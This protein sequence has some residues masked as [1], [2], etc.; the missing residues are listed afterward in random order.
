MPFGLVSSETV[1]NFWA[2]NTRRRVLYDYPNGTAPLMALTSLMETESTPYPEFKWEEKRW[3]SIKTITATGPTSNTWLYL[4]GAT[5]TAGAPA[6][7]TAGQALRVYVADAS[8]FQADDSI[9]IYN[10]AQTVGTTEL[11]GIVTGIDSAASPTFIEFNLVAAPTSTVTNVAGNLG[12]YVVLS[13][14]AY[15]EGARSRT[16]RY[17]FPY[18]VSNFT[19]IHKTPFEMTRTAL[20]EPTIYDKSGAYKDQFKENGITHLAG[21]EH[22]AFFGRKGLSTP[23]DP[24]TGSVVS[25]RT[26]GGLRYFLDLYEAGSPGYGGTGILS[27][28][29]ASDWRAEPAK[30]VIKLAGATITGADFDDLNTRV[31]DKYYTADCSKLVLCGNGYLA[32]I[33]SYYKGQVQFTSMRDEGFDGFDFK[34]VKHQTNAGTV[35]YKSAPLFNDPSLPYMRNSAFYIDI[36]C[37]KWRPLTDSDTQIQRMIQLPDADKRK[38]QWI[39]EGGFEFWY[40]DAFM[41]IENLG[42]ITK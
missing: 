23:V 28:I 35:Y 20:K 27:D 12:K 17:K 1:D 18:D 4:G 21:I 39:T 30:R 8:N 10:V 40:P 26:S 13:G 41:Y 34:L 32:K 14:S 16:G 36:A 19:Q 15:A 38:D 25:R 33:E 31:F 3:N 24:D 37:T 6:T 29:R 2:L 42:G 11:N 5:T 22:T 9:I 7:L